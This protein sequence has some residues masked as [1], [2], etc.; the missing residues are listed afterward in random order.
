MNTRWARRTLLVVAMLVLWATPAFVGTPRPASSQG[1][2]HW[3]YK[4]VDWVCLTL[5]C[6]ERRVNGFAKDGWELVQ[7][8]DKPRE[9]A[10]YIFRRPKQ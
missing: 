5:E 2:P 10:Y 3:D 4:F 7:G 6:N 9:R 8:V 1:V